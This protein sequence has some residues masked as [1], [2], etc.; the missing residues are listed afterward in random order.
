MGVQRYRRSLRTFCH[1]IL[2]HCIAIQVTRPHRRLYYAQMKDTGLD[3]PITRTSV[4]ISRARYSR[5]R[6]SE[7]EQY[8][9]RARGRL[10]EPG[11][12]SMLIKLGWTSGMTWRWTIISMQ[13][14]GKKF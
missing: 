6:I 12:Q 9:I 13:E 14:R 5:C 10:I 2:F 11:K 4:S 1:I 8:M 7:S 3:I